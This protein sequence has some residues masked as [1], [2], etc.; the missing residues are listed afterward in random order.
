MIE[1]SEEFEREIGTRLVEITWC[2]TPSAAQGV[3]I[4]I[5]QA[6]CAGCAGRRASLQGYEM[7]V[8]SYT[9][10][11]G[12]IGARIGGILYGRRNPGL[13]DSQIHITFVDCT[14]SQRTVC[15]LHIAERFLGHCALKRSQIIRWRGARAWAGTASAQD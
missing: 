1:E 6:C 9:A 4:L 11:R 10:N 13:I 5:H 12:R 2:A 14:P 8:I 15:R 7:A 3:D